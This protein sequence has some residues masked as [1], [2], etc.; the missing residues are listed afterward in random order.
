MSRVTGTQTADPCPDRYVE[1]VRTGS[2]VSAGGRGAVGHRCGRCGHT[3]SRP[4]EDDLEVHDIIGVDLPDTTLYGSV[5]QVA[6][7]R[8]QVDVRGG[9]RLL[10]V[11]RWRVVIY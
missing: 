2:P 10:W 3:W 1:E 8:V 7:A 5:R 4:V 6:G 9:G 11:E